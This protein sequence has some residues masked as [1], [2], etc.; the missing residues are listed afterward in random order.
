MDLFTLYGTTEEN[1]KDTGASPNESLSCQIW[2]AVAETCQSLHA[3]GASRMTLP[4]GDDL[5]ESGPKQPACE[6]GSHENRGGKVH[7]QIVVVAVFKF[8]WCGVVRRVGCPCK[9]WEALCT[10]IERG[11]AVF[12]AARKPGIQIKRARQ[13]SIHRAKY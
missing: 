1:S 5:Y 12:S 6:P 7:C 10:G 13:E 4:F 9:C 2:R 3:T 11:R 8:K